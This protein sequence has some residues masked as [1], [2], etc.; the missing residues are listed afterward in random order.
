MSTELLESWGVEL[1]KQL[2]SKLRSAGFACEKTAHAPTS[3]S[4][5]V[6]DHFRCPEDFLDFAANGE[7][8]SSSSYFR[9]GPNTICYGR[10]CR[11]T[12]ESDVWSSL[13]DI[14]DDVV[15]IDGKVGLPFDPTEVIDNLRLE[16]YSY[17]GLSG[18][19]RT[20]KTVYYW[21]R[22]FMNQY[23]RKQVQRFHARN[24]RKLSFPQWP[25]DTTVENVCET[26]LL[27]SLMA[28]G[29]ES[30]PFVWFW[31]HGARGC[32]LMT[33]DVE[34]E[35]G[36]DF[37]TDLM[38]ID[39]SFGIK[40]SFQIVPEER[41]AVSAE[42][43]DTIRNRGFELYDNRQEFLRRAAE[44]NRYMVEYRAKGFRSGVLYRGPEWYD[45]FDFS[46]DMSIPNVAHLDP[47][48]G[49]CCTVMPY[50][51]GN[52]LELPVTTTQDY[53]VFHVLNERSIDLWKTQVDLIFRKHGL[54]SF[55]IHP[56]YVLEEDTKLVYKALLGSLRALRENEQ[57][58]CPLPTD[59]D[60]W[61]RAR[62]KMSVEKDG[63]SWCIVGEGAERAV[64]AYARNVNGK[65]VY[66]V[67]GT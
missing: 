41:Y 50:F 46:F 61:W 56:D 16:R 44:I 57:M 3:L 43:L 29:V 10:S 66:E 19:E 14:L 51:I 25:V 30:V 33:H 62:S 60:A 8:S 31:P 42:L 36:R 58:W 59:I 28:K 6:L 5:N 38:D 23:A 15:I 67:T 64:L 21:L 11:S 2:Q 12:R 1:K 49:G 7:M 52:V 39:D 35:R 34:T 40:A 9:F 24:W 54:A 63:N 65:L 26:L 17:R 4:Q 22:P 37:C 55:I 48:R 53:T 27:Q 13:Y 47:Q 45:S 18:Y 20:L 32:V